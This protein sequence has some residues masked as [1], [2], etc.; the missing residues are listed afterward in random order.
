[1]AS[2]ASPLSFA[3]AQPPTAEEKDSLE[4]SNY[5]PNSED[6]LMQDNPVQE[7]PKSFKDKLVNG[8]FSSMESLVSYEEICA[9]N[10]IQVFN[11]MED[12]VSGVKVRVLEV[13]IPKEIH[14]KLCAPWRNSV[15]IKLLGKSIGFLA[16]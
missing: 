12:P 11:I 16:L 13:Y 15:I 1:M 9:A 10:P 3:P 14:N 7:S 2:S 5:K 4:G 8:G 6:V